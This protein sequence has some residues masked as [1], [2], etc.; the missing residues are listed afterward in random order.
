ME[1]ALSLIRSRSFI[2]SALFDILALTVIYFLPTLTHFFSFPL[3]YADPMRIVLILCLAHT[4]KSN[5]LI[6]A[7]TL[8]VFS[9]IIA[10]HP[11]MYKSLLIASELLLNL[12]FFYIISQKIKNVFGS[13]IISIALSKLFYYTAKYFFISGGLIEGELVTTPILIQAIAAV[14][15]S[16]YAYFIL[17]NRTE[18]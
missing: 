5:A 2:K 1:N 17:R 15:F 9:F 3:Y 8:P 16:V 6:I 18:Q 7:L 4:S 13:M 12:A 14:I 10:S 11:S